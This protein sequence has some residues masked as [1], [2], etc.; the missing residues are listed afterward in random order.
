MLVSGDYLHR[1]YLFRLLTLVGAFFALAGQSRAASH[2]QARLLVDSTVV[3]PDSAFTVAIE[4]SMEKGWH[5]YWQN[6][7]ESGM[8]TKVYWNSLP[9]IRVSELQWPIPEKFSRAGLVT[10]GY[11]H[12]VLLL[13]TIT[14]S[15]GVPP[16]PIDLKA[17]ASWLE[18]NDA[19]IRGSAALEKRLLVGTTAQ[20]SPEKE[21]IEIGRNKLPRQD[22]ALNLRASLDPAPQSDK[23][24][25][26]IQFT[27]SGT[28]TGPAAF[29]FF[30]F[31]NPNYE[32]RDSAEA[33]G[34]ASNGRVVR[35]LVRKW[36]GEWP[37][38][39]VGLLVVWQTKETAPAA[40]DVRI[41]LDR[42]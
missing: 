2:T 14:I 32:L 20:S 33:S 3:A 7:G 5:T 19:C 25:V 39:L 37:K 12:R 38:D 23:G 27:P 6:P 22:N 29:D 41:P 40:F 11:S 4:L 17:T 16:G 18:C 8:A 42:Q 9:G 21:L 35:K 1:M 24:A 15:N 10:Y 36:Q 13:A 26:L 31:S 28:G 34:K 30:P